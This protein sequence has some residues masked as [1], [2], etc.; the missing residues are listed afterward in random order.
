MNKHHTIN[1]IEFP[2]TNLEE[3]KRFYSTVFNWKFTD[4]GPD[5]IAFE[6]GIL[7]GGFS[8]SN[9]KHVAGGPLVILYS[10]NLEETFMAVTNHGGKI[11]QPVFSFPGGRRFHFVDPSGNELGVWSK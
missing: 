3:I 2:G 6:D 5:Y 10:D 4:F 8:K 7:E 1:Y 11:S 9:Q